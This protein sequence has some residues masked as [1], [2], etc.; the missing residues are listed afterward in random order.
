MYASGKSQSLCSFLTDNT[1]IKKEYSSG[2][3][4]FSF[5]FF[6]FEPFRKMFSR[7]H[8]SCNIEESALLNKCITVS[9]HEQPTIA[10]VQ[11]ISGRFQVFLQRLSFIA[12][13]SSLVHDPDSVDGMKSLSVLVTSIHSGVLLWLRYTVARSRTMS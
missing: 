7:E 11:H 6:C 3:S 9:P 13:V 2:W 12:P 1:V 5:S 10:S 4:T 8:S